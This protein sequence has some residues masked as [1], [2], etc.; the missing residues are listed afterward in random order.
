VLWEPLT[1]DDPARVGE[2]ELHGR[3]RGRRTLL[4]RG[5]DGRGNAA[6]LRVPRPDL[7]AV[8]AQLV[9]VEA[10]ALRRL[11]GQ[12]APVL[13]A[14]GLQDSPPW[15]AMTPIADEGDP[16]VQPTRLTE[17]FDRALTDGTAPFDTLRGLLVSCY[18]AN[19]V[20]LCH[21][22]NLVPATLDADSVYVLRRTVVLGD[23]SDCAVDGVY[24]GSGAAPTREDNVRALGE[25]LQVIS[26]K[27]GWDLPSLPEGMHLWQG[28]TWE[29]LRRLVLRCV[30]PDP[31]ER[32]TASEVAEVLARYVAR[33]R[34]QL[35][36]AGP[37]A[38]GESRAPRGPLTPP[39]PD[40][41]APRP[42]LRLPRFGTARRQALHRL[43][44]L[45]APLPRSRRLT[46][47]GAY[48]YSGRATT[49]M[50]L[51]SLLAAVRGEP[52]L[53]LDGSPS[54]GSLD[55]F[56][57]RRN[58]A[59]VR[60][61]AALPADVPYEEIRARTTRLPSGLEV[62]AHRSGHFS[63]NPAHQQ[64]Y[65]RVLAQTAHYYPF[66]LTDWAPLRLDGSAAAV[67]DHTDRLILCC[68]TADWFLAA[69]RQV[70]ERLRTARRWRLADEAIVVVTEVDGPSA[71][72][73]PAALASRIGVSVNQVVAVPF[74]RALSS[75][76][77]QE[78]ELNG[79]RTPTLNVFLD[80]AERVVRTRT[81]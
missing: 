33:T 7:P 27:A 57:T 67:L 61:L 68:G 77:F 25:L 78:R 51:G 80:L 49:T 62:V 54:E 34:L 52:V 38:E 55:A 66:V 11:Q 63:P 14:A 10:E 1:D 45:R 59:V 73:V 40:A 71:R 76:F 74:D 72:R 26:S 69:A 13:L 46:L 30:D 12:Y 19:A 65:V 64:E 8:N 43:D 2:Y 53:A 16:D 81:H 15:L 31:A 58:P 29:Q 47:I 48:H 70:L 44:R 4:Y 21:L 75:S 6:V 79:L 22:N 28:D 56:L 39:A 50:V 23:L 5:V 24:L 42:E 36:G 60:D 3:R 37:T 41:G 9:T 18:L 17:L 35:A 32:P 20:A